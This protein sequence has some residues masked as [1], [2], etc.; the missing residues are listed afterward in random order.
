MPVLTYEEC[1]YINY[2]LIQCKLRAALREYAEKNFKPKASS[3]INTC[4][5]SSNTKRNKF[6]SSIKKDK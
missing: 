2:G 4:C 6:T 5:P 3:L 1:A